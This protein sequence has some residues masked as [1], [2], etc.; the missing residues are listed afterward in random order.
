MDRFTDFITV[1]RFC[2]VLDESL[3]LFDSG[4]VI[5]NV[6]A[7]CCVIVVEQGDENGFGMSFLEIL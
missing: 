4:L 2:M 6:D 1:I 3:A 7:D 5:A